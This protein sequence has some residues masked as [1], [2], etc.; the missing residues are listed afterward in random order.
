MRRIERR[1]GLK[2]TAELADY[3]RLLQE[4]EREAPLLFKDLLIGVTGFFRE[5]GA[6]KLLETEVIQKIV[7]EKK[8][9][10]AIRVWVP[11]CSSGEEPYSIG[12]I[13]LEQ[14]ELMKKD[15][16]IQIFA[17]DI[18]EGALAVART[19]IYPQ[20]IVSDIS[21][22]RLQ[23]FF[24][25][26][27]ESYQV[28]KRLRDSVVFAVQNLINDPPFS[29]LDLISCRNLLIYLETEIQ[30]KIISLF[31]FVLKESGTL[32]LGR[33]ETIGQQEELFKAISKKHRLYRRM[34]P[35]RRDKVDF[36][37]L[38]GAGAFRGLGGGV[39]QRSLKPTDLGEI[40]NQL[41]LKEFV[42][43]SVLIN[44]RYEILYLY[45]HSGPYLEMTTGEPTQDLMAITR[46]G[47]RS[48]LR[49]AIQ[50]AIQQKETIM[51]KARV[52][53]KGEYAPVHLTV[54]PVNAPKVAE[55]LLVVTFSDLAVL[56]KQKDAQGML[57]ELSHASIM[58]DLETE[59]ASTKEDLRG[60]IE[61]LEA[62]N[63][64]LKTSNEEVMSMNEEL[65]SSNEELETSKEE[66]QSLNEELT[67][68]NNQLQDKIEELAGT[69]DDLSRAC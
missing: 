51:S 34:G 54:F 29:K 57:T 68:V 64:E 15:C 52:K 50:K 38:S 17:S 36:P 61:E 25:K 11:G 37:M 7:S 62:A 40:T 53:R 69:N 20:N 60:T 24:I 14:I 6:F 32:F 2:H 41:L 49:G 42:P 3:L 46:E 5:P 4:D 63:E 19:G 1:M 26:R 44:A 10:D 39:K 48:T 66:L 45:G 21:P 47:L 13:L 58:N 22:E 56:E 31:H 9:E 67:T 59:L 23:R 12:M 16:P 30:K 33:S 43:F 65:Q 8:P 55:G 35:T 18:D 28:G 27:G